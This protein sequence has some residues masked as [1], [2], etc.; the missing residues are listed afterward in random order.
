MNQLFETS[1]QPLHTEP[2]MSNPTSSNTKPFSE[3]ASRIQ[4]MSQIIHKEKVDRLRTNIVPMN[5]SITVG[6]VIGILIIVFGPF[7]QWYKH[8]TYGS[9]G[10]IIP[11][12]MAGM[13]LARYAPNRFISIKESLSDALTF[14]DEDD[15][16]IPE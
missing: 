10:V 12:T 2:T 3:W 15:V 13:L 8:F 6:L 11:M 1:G 9:W 16:T 7:P 4:H 5:W 14:G